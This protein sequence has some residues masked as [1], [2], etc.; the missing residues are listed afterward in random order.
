MWGST[1]SSPSGVWGGAPTE[2]KLG[3]YITLNLASAGSKFDD[4]NAFL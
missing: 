4:I 2:I 1:V 3:R